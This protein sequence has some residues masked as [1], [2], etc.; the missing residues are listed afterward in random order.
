MKNNNNRIGS[1]LEAIILYIILIVLISIFTSIFYFYF[2][3]KIKLQHI[4]ISID[5]GFIILVSV[6]LIFTKERLP[7]LK[8]I[9]FKLLIMSL[10]LILLLSIF[11]A[12]FN[13]SFFL[14]SYYTNSFSFVLKFDSSLI[15][16]YDFYKLFR[17]LFLLPI[18]EEIFY[19]HILQKKLNK[20]L[21][22]FF[23]IVI[24]SLFFSLTHLDFDNFLGMTLIGII[25]GY[26]YNKT[27][28][29]AIP[30]LI[31]IGIN[32]LNIFTI[33]NEQSLN[34]SLSLSIFFILNIIIFLLV[35]NF[36]EK[37]KLKQCIKLTKK[38]S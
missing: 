9:N 12:Y 7:L 29:M 1:V 13:P 36:D 18:L 15:E 22:L 8:K 10:F 31:H 16:K 35:Y 27:N 4:Q 17:I 32:F 34:N 19:R 14:E 5:L 26:I 20:K 30:I 6:Y 24:S 38:K 21:P 33:Y 23:A 25:L 3:S 2:D 37:I 11:F 28:N